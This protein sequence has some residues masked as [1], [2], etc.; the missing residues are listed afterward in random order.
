MHDL[1]LLHVVERDKD[2]DGKAANQALGH[3]LKIVHLDELVQVH[4]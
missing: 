1:E 4:A 2:L 3:A